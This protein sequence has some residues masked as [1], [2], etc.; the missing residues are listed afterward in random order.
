M[1]QQHSDTELYDVERKTIQRTTVDTKRLLFTRFED[2]S[3]E[4]IYEIFEL[5][6][7][8][9]LF[10]IFSN[11]N[12]RFQNLLTHPT[13]RI[14]M[15]LSSMSESTFHR[16]RAFGILPN[17][18]RIKSLHLSSPFAVDLIFSPPRCIPKFSQLKTLILDDINSRY[19]D[20]LLHF[21]TLL[22]YL[23]SLILSLADRF[24]NKM[25]LY[26]RIFLIPMLKY[27]KLSYQAGS[28]RML[29]P[30][31][32][33]QCKIAALLSYTPR[34]RHLSCRKLAYDAYQTMEMPIVPNNLTKA[35]FEFFGLFNFDQFEPLIRKNFRQLHCLRISISKNDRSYLDAKQW[36]RLILTSM[37][38]LRIF[39]IQY[40]GWVYKESSGKTQFYDRIDQFNSTFWFD[41]QWFFAHQSYEKEHAISVLF[42]S[43]QPYRRQSYILYSHPEEKICPHRQQTTFDTV[44]HLYIDEEQSIANCLFQFPKCTNLTLLKSFCKN[45]DS[46]I[47]SLH[48]IIPLMQLTNLTIRCLNL[49]FDTIIE[50]LHSTPNIQI[51][52][53]DSE[54]PLELN[55]ISIEQTEKLRLIS[56]ENKIQSL[57]ISRGCTSK[58]AEVFINLCR[59]VQ[60]I[61]MNIS[62]NEFESTVRVLL[63][64]HNINSH[65]LRLL[66][67]RYLSV[68]SFKKIEHMVHAEKLLENCSIKFV[69]NRLYLWW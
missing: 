32:T 18:H 20:Q 54:Y 10:E 63:M 42:Y 9:D 40:K 6:D 46:T 66:I 39:D 7:G 38:Y 51:L 56:N 52:E 50:V 43:I 3:N 68:T 34:L 1:K 28:G 24:R 14:N 2:L 8:Y 4:L 21:L 26:P 59:R 17:K 16:F 37:A 19:L 45:C 15:N 67:L 5:L 62:T 13:L 12:S 29:L 35:S 33:N 30:I 58:V 61:D 27:C 31:T 65:H 41:R 11:L 64:K 57:T 23:S 47:T 69:Y 48:R 44:R 25:I 22:P 60:R 55:P 36:E 53:V 49:F